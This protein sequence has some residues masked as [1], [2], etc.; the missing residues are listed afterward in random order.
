MAWPGA[1]AFVTQALSGRGD[2]RPTHGGTEQALDH[3]RQ[4]EVGLLRRGQTLEYRN[5]TK[6]HGED[7][8]GGEMGVH[9]GR[10]GGDK[11]V[12]AVFWLCI[13]CTGSAVNLH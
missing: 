7:L 12:K 8:A 1:D 4:E 2:T 3:S 5:S 10:A 6:S 11:H 9:H 13:V